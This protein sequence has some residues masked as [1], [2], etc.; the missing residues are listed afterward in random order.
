MT[1]HVTLMAMPL[2]A[3]PQGDSGGKPKAPAKPKEPKAPK[4][5]ATGLL[6]VPTGPEQGFRML[7][8]LPFA[9]GAHG[10]GAPPAYYICAPGTSGM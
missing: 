3:Q 6:G 8:G 4:G 1:V 10:P 9:T 2:A 5:G 7:H